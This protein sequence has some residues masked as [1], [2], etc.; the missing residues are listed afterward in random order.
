MIIP[1][2][3]DY[4]YKLIMYMLRQMYICFILRF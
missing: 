2:E 4:G 3:S 1:L